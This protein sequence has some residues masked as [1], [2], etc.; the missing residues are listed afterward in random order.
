MGTGLDPD[1][2]EWRELKMHK[3]DV[4]ALILAIVGALNWGLVALAEF[5]LVA[6]I[7]GRQLG[8]KAIRVALI[9]RLV[10]RLLGHFLLAAT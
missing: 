8:G 4:A 2:C 9:E 5:D 3:L 10:A 7:V 6:E 1:T